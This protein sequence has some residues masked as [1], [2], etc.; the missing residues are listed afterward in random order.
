MRKLNDRVAV[1]TGA[2]GGIGKALVL[3]LARAGMHVVLAD[4]NEPAVRQLAQEVRALGRRCS[5]VCTDVR[6]LNDVQSLLAYTLV[7]QGDCHLL[8]NNAGVLQAAHLFDV[9]FAEWQRVMEINLWGVL[10]GCRVFG[11][12]FRERGAGHIVNVGSVG[13][14]FPM[15]GFTMY[16][17]SKFAVAGFSQQLR[18]ELASRNVGVTLVIPG[19]IDTPLLDRPDTGLTHLN[20]RLVMKVS[21]TPEGLARAVRRAVQGNRGVMYY[22]YDTFPMRALSLLPQWVRDVI[23]AAF[24]RAVLKLLRREGQ[25]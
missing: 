10:H 22:G 11:E 16:S 25:A 24:A 3:E 5:A 12:Y 8:I 17:T 18:W 21:A 4:R 7:E 9:A 23:G 15:P 20:T 6:H 13:G 1:V 19:L 14:L 2:A